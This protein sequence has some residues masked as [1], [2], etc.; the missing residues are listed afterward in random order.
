MIR[1]F[2]VYFPGRT[3][4]LALTE[5]VLS[6]LT[7]LAAMCVWFGRDVDL[8]ILYDHGLLR[9]LF[10]STVCVLCMHYYDLY[11]SF[12]MRTFRE[13]V[14]R[15]VHVLGTVCI[16]LAVVYYAYPPAQLSRGPIIIWL[17][18]EEHT[19]ELQSLRH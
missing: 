13:V 4:L 8:A 5:G 11:D 12:V 17:R 10:A 2:N 7:L 9:V 16:I 3:L 19:S 1:L 18:S 6:V 14:S 15:V